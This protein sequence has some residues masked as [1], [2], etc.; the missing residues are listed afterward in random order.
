MFSPYLFTKLSTKHILGFDSDPS[1]QIPNTMNLQTKQN[2]TK[3]SK[4]KLL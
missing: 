2:K 4:S 3:Q 1:S